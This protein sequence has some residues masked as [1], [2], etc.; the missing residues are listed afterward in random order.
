ME[1]CGFLMQKMGDG[2]FER[3]YF[4]IKNGLMM[5]FNTK[6]DVDFFNA[7]TRVEFSRPAQLF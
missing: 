3:Y 2:D 4:V 7:S 1:R 6:H 5:Q